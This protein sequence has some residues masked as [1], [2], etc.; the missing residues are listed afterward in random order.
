MDEKIERLW[1]IQEEMLALLEEVE[2]LTKGTG[3]ESIARGYFVGNIH[4]FLID[5]SYQTGK[6]SE[7]IELVRGDE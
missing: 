5:D 1:E 2:D 6:I 3:A 7:I 4:P